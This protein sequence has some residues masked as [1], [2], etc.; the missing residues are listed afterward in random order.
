M[1][2]NQRSGELDPVAEQR[3]LIFRI[4]GVAEDNTKKN[5]E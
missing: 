2:Q 1:N 3:S 4:V 5:Q